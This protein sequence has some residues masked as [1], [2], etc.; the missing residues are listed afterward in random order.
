MTKPIQ[1]KN[2]S[3]G[4][5]LPKICVPLTGKTEEEIKEEGKKT[6]EAGAELVEWRADFFEALEDLWKK[7]FFPFPTYWDR[8][9]FFSRS[10]RQKKGEIEKSEQKI[11]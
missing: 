7:C 4:E 8:F 5:G 11:M 1:I 6:V 9:P 10:V 3:L 2:I